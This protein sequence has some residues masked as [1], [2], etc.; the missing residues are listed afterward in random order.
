MNILMTI[1]LIW[2]VIGI[3]TY[4]AY[5]EDSV[6]AESNVFSIAIYILLCPIAILSALLKK[7]Q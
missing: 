6:K 5:V 3:Y 1:I 2:V 7:E 4:H